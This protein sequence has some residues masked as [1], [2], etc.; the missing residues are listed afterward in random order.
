MLSKV[1]STIDSISEQSGR[2][3]MWL[4]LALIGAI[5]IEVGAR[6]LFSSPTPW[7]YDL[8]YMLGG[9]LMVL[10]G[11]YTLLHEGHVRVDVLYSRLSTRGKMILDSALIMLFFF[12]LLSVLFRFSLEAAIRSFVTQEVSSVGIWEP[13]M[14]PFRWVFPVGIG[15][16]LLQGIA[17]FIRSVR[18]SKTGGRP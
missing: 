7:S 2:V 12:P 16:T 18:T 11:A 8:S 5:S 17:W 1:L 13:I 9:S 10:G 14:W 4:S 6:Y 15:L 3:F